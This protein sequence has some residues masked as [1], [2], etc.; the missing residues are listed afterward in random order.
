MSN[1]LLHAIESA[2][3]GSSSK[4]KVL[5][6]DVNETLLDLAPLKKQIAQALG[7]DK[8]VGEW[9]STLLHYSLVHTLTQ[10]YVAF[11]QIGANAMMML[12]E[13]EG[14]QI[15]A[16]SAL[17]LVETGLRQLEPYPDVASTLTHLK[18]AGFTLVTLTN[19]SSSAAKAKLAYAQIYDHFDR[20]FTV[21]PVK[22][23]K[24]APAAY[25]Q[26]FESLEIE[27]DQAMMIAAHPWD[28]MGARAVGMQTCFVERPGKFNYLSTSY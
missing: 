1:L 23:F 21:E 15:D 17:D 28:L 12:S 14:Q 3:S 22:Q 7:D 5:V 20:H 13:R 8:L 2:L 16:A 19:S 6:F 10:N 9:F 4:L 18:E 27:A 24:P 11:S 26:V 25:Q